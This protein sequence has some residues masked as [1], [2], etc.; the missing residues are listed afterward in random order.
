MS[1]LK[2]GQIGKGELSLD[3][4]TYQEALKD[5]EWH[6]I[7]QVNWPGEFPY[8]PVVNFQIAHNSSHIVLHYTVEEEYVKAKYIRPNESVWEDSCVEFFISFDNKKQ[9]YN[10]EF[11]V[12][13]TGL[14]GFGTADKDTRVRLE[15]AVI[16]QISTLTTVVNKQG[17]KR[18]AI[19]L[20]IP[21]TVF[22]NIGLKSFDGIKADAN[23]YKCGDALPTPHFISWSKIN[24]ATPNF[25][26]P[27]YFGPV[28]F[29]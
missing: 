13:G 21:V 26:L 1:I 17:A 16:E 5:Q 19:V 8:K 3:Y 25:H 4:A 11:N 14:I 15:P 23:F 10:F 28:E 29:A 12:L 27:E 24:H 7:E 6:A 22:E 20:L 18:W 9:Y 2:V